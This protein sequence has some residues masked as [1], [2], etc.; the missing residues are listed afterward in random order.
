MAR[1]G[2]WSK[3]FR[4][5]DFVDFT[6]FLVWTLLNFMA[7]RDDNNNVFHDVSK[8][9]H[10]KC[11]QL[12]LFSKAK[13]GQEDCLMLNIYVPEVEFSRRTRK[14]PVMVWI[15]GGALLIGSNNYNENGPKHFMKKEVVMV[16]V[17]YRLGPL[18]FLSMGTD[19]VPGTVL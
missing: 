11:P 1:Y 10:V 9:S 6:S 3:K 14:L 17:N 12:S 8:E 19:S 7:H 4:E 15:H 5:I 18:G 13:K 2:F 16:T